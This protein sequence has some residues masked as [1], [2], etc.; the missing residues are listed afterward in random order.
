M[1]SFLTN[2]NQ[3]RINNLHY[4]GTVRFCFVVVNHMDSVLAASQ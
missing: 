4:H 2:T 1:I 3:D